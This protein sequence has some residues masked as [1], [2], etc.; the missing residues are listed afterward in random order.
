MYKALTSFATN[1]YD[2][3]KSQILEDDFTNQDEINEFLN[4][5]YIE[6]YDDT[7]EITENGQYD[8]ADYD[9]VDVDV[10]GSGGFV[11]P[12]GMKFQGSTLTDF[13]NLDFSEVTSANSMFKD[14]IITNVENLDMPNCTD[15][16]YMFNGSKVKKVSFKSIGNTINISSMFNSCENLEEVSFP[17]NF[18]PQY[19]TS[20]FYRCLK[21]ETFPFNNIK[22]N[23]MSGMCL[24]CVA[25]KNVPFLDTSNCLTMSSCFSNCSSLTAESLNNILA[26]CI[27]ATKIASSSEKTLKNVGL[28]QDQVTICETLSNWDDFV[29]AGWSSGY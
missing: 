1:N 2:V 13:P 20:A 18:A 17:N 14:C 5:G 25:L 10:E 27:S 23:N 9:N 4:I 15:V 21:L 19:L 28:T 16:S 29:A 24:N 6:E 3:R 7:L 22:P 11:V 8:V 12:N 26:M